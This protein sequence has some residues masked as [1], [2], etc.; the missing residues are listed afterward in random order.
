MLE[1][2]A[3][4][5]VK[6]TQSWFSRH[7]LIYS[8][9]L[10]E[11]SCECLQRPEF[12]SQGSHDKNV[13]GKNYLIYWQRFCMAFFHSY[14]EK[15][16][17]HPGCDRGVNPCER[18]ECG[19]HAD[20][21]LPWQR[22]SFVYCLRTK[23]QSAT[24]TNMEHNEL[25]WTKSVARSPW[26]PPF[27]GWRRR[28]QSMSLSLSRRYVMVEQLL[29]LSGYRLVNRLVV[30]GVL[31]GSCFLGRG[32]W[33]LECS[34][35]QFSGTFQNWIQELSILKALQFNFD[36]RSF[37][38]PDDIRTITNLSSSKSALKTHLFRSYFNGIFLIDVTF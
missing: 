31:R 15:S 6:S 36:F 7:V 28:W 8:P 9:T 26:I 23:S 12:S 17:W 21:Y 19:S 4:K 2:I 14:S 35:I 33:A 38:I 25:E 11:D 16:W 18:R 30:L 24:G 3:L 34:W 29:S 37:R 5:I 13:N 32:V 27:T 20:V 22:D 1:S 10:L